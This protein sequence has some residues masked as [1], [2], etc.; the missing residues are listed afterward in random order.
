MRKTIVIIVVVGMIGLL[1]YGLRQHTSATL[2]PTA[3]TGTA[4]AQTSGAASTT[5][6]ATGGYKDG[7]FTGA[8]QYNPYGTVQIGVV[9]SGGKISDVNFVQ[10]P[11]GAGHTNYVTSAVEPMLK[12]ETLSAQNANIS[13]ISGATYTS[14]TYQA[15]L[16]SAL[17]QAAAG[18]S[19]SSNSSSNTSTG[20]GA[21]AS[22]QTQSVP[23]GLSGGGDN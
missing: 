19:S 14:Q 12:Q 9:I 5:A 18:G 7:T 3:G 4:A 15:S 6:S 21:S 23:S 11:Q 22:T 2:L 8:A 16:Q 1:N 17:N 20:T 10:M 13:F